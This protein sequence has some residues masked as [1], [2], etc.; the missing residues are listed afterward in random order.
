MILTP[1]QIERLLHAGDPDEDGFGGGWGSVELYDGGEWPVKDVAETLTAYAARAELYPRL[2][3][4]L[5]RAVRQLEAVPEDVPG[6]TQR[7]HLCR[8][9]RELAKEAGETWA[10]GNGETLAKIVEIRI[11]DYRWHPDEITIGDA[12]TLSERRGG[13]DA[14]SD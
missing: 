12:S 6:W 10:M 13:N 2:L 8:Q 1:E 9:A 11:G 5:R 14:D 7:T 4:T 3:D